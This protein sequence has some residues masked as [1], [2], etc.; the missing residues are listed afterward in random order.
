[1]SLLDTVLA[2]PAA[3]FWLKDAIKAA[4][5]RDALNA[6]RDAEILVKVLQERQRALAGML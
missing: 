5:K 1:M 3:S 4:L 2:D 6:L